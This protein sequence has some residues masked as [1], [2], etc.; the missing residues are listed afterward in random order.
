MKKILVFIIFLFS[1]AYSFSSI[2][3]VNSAQQ[4]KLILNQLK[5]GDQI[6]IQDGTYSLWENIVITA[7]GTASAPI[8]ISAANPGKVIFTGMPVSGYFQLKGDF[9]RLSG[10]IFRENILST[11]NPLIIID[12]GNYNS[13]SQCI[14]EKNKTLV[15]FTPL[16]VIAGNGSHNEV[17]R[18]KF[19]SNTDNQDLQVKISK[20]SNPQ[21]SLI[22]EN[23]FKDKAPVSWKNGNGGE[24]VQI[25]QDPV[26]LGSMV[27][28]TTVRK[29]TF[30]R[31]NAE[32]EVLSNKSS[33]NRYEG[34]IFIDN[35]GELV[36]RGGHDC[37]I[38]KNRF[39][40]GIGGLRING[41]GHRVIQ[42]HFNDLKTAIRLMY[43]ME[44]GKSAIGFYIAASNCTLT[45]N[46]IRNCTTGLLNG[47][48]KNADWTGKFDTKRYPSPVLQNIAPFENEMRE[49][50]FKK[51]KTNALSN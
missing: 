5:P 14:F 19:I 24:C 32:P 17:R 15:Q 36:M 31:C 7:K 51:T 39:H 43:G 18:C 27:S 23:Y 40:G 48:G 8:L 33:E 35:E 47:D 16:V 46:T 34:N 44:K 45:K 21:F 2:Y 22:A 30:I 20:T 9:I 37:W 10:F 11:S 38:T 3:Q 12:Q 42:N 49:N 26:L 28:R 1:S 6:K 13:I 25:G 4:L 41:T 50:R 29:N